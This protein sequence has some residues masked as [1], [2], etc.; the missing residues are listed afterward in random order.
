MKILVLCLLVTSCA[1]IPKKET[2][3]NPASSQVFNG[4]ESTVTGTDIAGENRKD[5]TDKPCSFEM[6]S[7]DVQ[8]GCDSCSEYKVKS[9][10]DANEVTLKRSGTDNYASS[11]R[12]PA[13]SDF[14]KAVMIKYFLE[15]DQQGTISK[16]YKSASFGFS[17][18]SKVC[19]VK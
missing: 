14:P 3:R 5:E 10:F 15:F 19:R 1:A 7:I 9:S 6:T 17:G 4:T 2:F 16:F 12:Y 13:D 18:T 11:K 8:A